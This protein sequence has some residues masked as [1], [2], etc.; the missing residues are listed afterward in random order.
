M[1]K[2]LITLAALA[3]VS[4]AQADTK[5]VE[6]TSFDSANSTYSSTGEAL[7]IS[8]DTYTGASISGGSLTINNNGRA[9][10][11]IS[12]LGINL[13]TGS[14][15][16]EFTTS[17]YTV[18]GAPMFSVTTGANG[19]QSAGFGT[20]YDDAFKWAFSADGNTMKNYK[21]EGAADSGNGGTF[22]VSFLYDSVQEKNYVEAYLD[23]VAIYERTEIVYE[24]L[25]KSYTSSIS[26]ELQSLTF[27]GWGS[28]SANQAMTLTSFSISETQNL[29]E[30]TTAT[31]S[32]LAL[33]G[34]AARRRRR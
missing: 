25:G 24:D 22:T 32:L 7:T 28:G 30:P 26:G 27:N 29:P 16:F 13:A 12:D 20:A 33:A 23:G 17:S 9:Y 8:T 14:Y 6:W 11:D 15:T 34:L 4:A 3:M 21:G 31:L 5:L 18:N 1:K 19:T 10:V 2:T